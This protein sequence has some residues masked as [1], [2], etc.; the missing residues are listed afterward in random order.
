MVNLDPVIASAPSNESALLRDWEAS[1]VPVYFDFGDNERNLW[2]L[3]PRIRTGTAY[4]SP[5]RKSFFLRVHFEG[6]PFD[7]RCTEAVECAAA[8]RAIAESW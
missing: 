2:R 5:V 6:L 3:D 4:L 7:E 8:E 1:R